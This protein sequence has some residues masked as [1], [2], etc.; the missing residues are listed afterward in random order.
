MPK[1]NYIQHDIF[2]TDFKVFPLKTVIF[3]VLFL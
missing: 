1:I 3:F 2:S